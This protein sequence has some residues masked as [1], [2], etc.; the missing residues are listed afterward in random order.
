MEEIVKKEDIKGKL[1]AIPCLIAQCSKI[2]VFHKMIKS[3]CNCNQNYNSIFWGEGRR[4]YCTLKLYE[5]SNRDIK[6]KIVT[7]LWYCHK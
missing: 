3:Q 2:S 7:I 1:R 5:L 4:T 6:I